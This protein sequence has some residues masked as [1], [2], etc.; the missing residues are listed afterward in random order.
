MT[1]V[2]AP[3]YQHLIEHDLQFFCM[4]TAASSRLR[5]MYSSTRVAAEVKVEKVEAAFQ[6]SNM[7]FI[8]V[9]SLP[10]IVHLYARWAANFL[11]AAAI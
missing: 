2:I 3:L 6:F 1:L 8:D 7:Y 11:H 9:G 4:I 5:W 10:L